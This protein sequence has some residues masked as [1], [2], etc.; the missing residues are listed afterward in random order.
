MK[1]MTDSMFELENILRAHAQRYPLMQPTDAVKLIYQNEFGG[2][3]LI[4][5]EVSCL[6][7]LRREYAS[8]AKDSH[9]PLYEEIGNGIVRVNL[10]AVKE[11]DL[12]QLGKDFI[13]CAATHQGSLERF[14]QKLDV[15]RAMTKQ[16]VFTFSPESLEAYLQAYAAANYPAVS[17]SEQY[18]AAYRPAYRVILQ[19]LIYP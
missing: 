2:G 12:E 6:N 8:V 9:A 7:Y 15:L 17:H 13:R 14:L 16:G 11:D 4:K 19:A 1:V 3:H 10:A 5:D 18:R